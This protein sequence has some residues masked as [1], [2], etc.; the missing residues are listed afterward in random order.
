MTGLP[1]GL[2]IT[3]TSANTVTVS[4]TPTAVGTFNLNVLATD[5]STGNGPFAVGQAFV[6]NVA[7]PTLVLSPA[8]G[9]VNAP[10]GQSFN[11]TYTASGGVGP[12]TYALTGALP[13]GLSFSNGTISGTPTAAGSFPI[14]VTAT[15]TGVTGAG[16]PFSVAQNYT[17]NVAAPT[18]WCPP[19]SCPA[20]CWAVPMAR[21]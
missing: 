19:G 6:L 16:A 21:R 18:L 2:A 5:S 12:Y 15:D 20:R 7:P 14:T 17:I 8:S 3:G 11:Q 9:A 4:G 10:Y 13:A 1:A